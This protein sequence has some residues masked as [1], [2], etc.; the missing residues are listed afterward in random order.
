MRRVER[1]WG[2]SLSN[3]ASLYSWSIQRPEQFWQSLWEFVGIIA[4]TRGDTVIQSP[5][6]MVGA[7]FFPQARLNFAENLLRR[8]DNDFAVIARSEDNVRRSMTHKELHN[9]VS[10]IAQA[11]RQVGVNPLDRV[12]AILPNVPET[13]A[14]MLAT[15]SIGAIWTSCSPDFGM[16]GL[17]D[18]IGQV[19]PKVLFV[20]DAYRYKGQRH[21]LIG[22]LRQLRER[23]LTA[24][25]VI[26]LPMQE[27]EQHSQ[28][29]AGAVAFG[30]F[31]A[32]FDAKEIDY[33]RLP[34]DQPA[35][36]LYTSGT[37]GVP[38][39][40]IHGAGG[41]LL[42]LMKEHWL[43]FDVKPRDRFFYFT[44]TGWNMWYTLIAALGPGGTI[45]M[46]DGSPFYPREATLF[47]IIQEEQVNIFGTSPKYIETIRRHHLWPQKSHDLA[48]LK[49][50]LSTGSPLS[51]DCFDYIYSNI[52]KDLRLSSISGGTEIMTT[53][54]NGNPIGPVYR[55]EL[56]VRTLGMRVEVVNEEGESVRGR[57]GE[58]VCTAPFPSRPLGFWNDVGNRRYH[59]SY[60]S[61]FRNVWTHGDYAEVTEHDGMLIYGR[62][63]AV[64]NPG[65]VR[66]G[67]AE[68][69]RPLETVQEI[70]DAIVVGQEWNGDERIVLFVR[71]VEGTMLD[72]ALITRIKDR[73]KQY[74][75]PR[76]VPDKVIQVAEIP[77]TV[78]GKKVELA[79][80]NMVHGR[81]VK[82]VGSLNN[83]GALKYFENLPDLM[84]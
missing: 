47:D 4:E 22:R 58:L 6:S 39:S 16:Q 27:E 23:L 43:H 55:G 40:V 78:N 12:A 41:V 36:I 64:L 57:K 33:A 62:S 30:D 67:T 61:R 24:E 18:R 10:R 82:S 74:A 63:D 68:I 70:A 20:V 35:F 37:T 15:S 54:V 60:F 5:D 80:K 46:Y 7:K 81:P 76:H 77:Y 42:Q 1:D 72:E 13:L 73:V 38:K 83:P 52:K 71:L 56:Q 75:T 49:T 53:F 2:V 79:V 65:G 48:P 17:V 9:L 44:T 50:I 8:S 19:D 25:H 32:P 51:P 28:W 66:I 29:P 21:D 3:Y 59:E 31:I 11:M 26:V 45:V 69:Y 34:F 84:T 14:A